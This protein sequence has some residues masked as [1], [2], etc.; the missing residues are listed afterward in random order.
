MFDAN[1]SGSLEQP[2][3]SVTDLATPELKIPKD[4]YCAKCRMS[5]CVKTADGGVNK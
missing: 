2:T 5:I 1:E 4:A 3:V